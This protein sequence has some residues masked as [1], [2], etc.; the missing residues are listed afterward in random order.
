MP[1][2][3]LLNHEDGALAAKISQRQEL[4]K[5]EVKASVAEF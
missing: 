4:L 1:P 2:T 5:P 3:P